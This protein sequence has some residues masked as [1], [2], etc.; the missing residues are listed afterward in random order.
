VQRE[1]A[2]AGQLD[3]GPV[4]VEAAEQLV[5]A[6]DGEKRRA[7]GHRFGQCGPLRS[8]VGRD[9]RLLAVLPAAYVVQ[10]DLPSVHVLANP[11]VRDLELVASPRR[12]LPQHGDV[13]AV[14]VDVQ[15]VRVE[16]PD[17]DLHAARSQ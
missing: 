15:V 16:M 4:P 10:V 14:G 17:A 3:T 1:K 5:A 7:A 11:D 6:A 2:A 9:Q 12:P 8:D 13:A